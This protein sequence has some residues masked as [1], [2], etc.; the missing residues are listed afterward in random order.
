MQEQPRIKSKA[1]SPSSG[2]AIGGK[3]READ[4]FQFDKSDEDDTTNMTTKVSNMHSRL[5]PKRA[6]VM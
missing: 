1:F 4:Y 2:G 3:N 5:S 6:F